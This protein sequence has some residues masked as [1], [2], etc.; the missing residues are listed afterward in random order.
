MVT[1]WGPQ[2][3]AKF[4]NITPI[5]LWFMVL[6]IIV[7]G[8]NLN[9]LITGWPHIVVYHAPIDQI[10][11]KRDSQPM[12]DDNSNVLLDSKTPDL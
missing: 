1:K 7:T 6:I 11:W 3:I 12:D 4:V 9:Q 5:S 8:A 10:A 2:T